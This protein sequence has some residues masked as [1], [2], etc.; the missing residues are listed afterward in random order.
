MQNLHK[1]LFSQ[2]FSLK[3][4]IV[5]LLHINTWTIHLTT[6]KV[7]CAVLENRQGKCG[8]SNSQE[9]DQLVSHHASPLFCFADSGRQPFVSLLRTEFGEE[10]HFQG[11][12][13]LR[14]RAEGEVH[15]LVE[16]LRDV[17]T[18]HVHPPREIRLR[19]AQFLHPAQDA[20]EKRRSDSVYDFHVL[21]TAVAQE[22]DPPVFRY[23]PRPWGMQPNTSLHACWMTFLSFATPIV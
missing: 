23:A 22:R 5:Q 13:E 9:I 7:V 6:S 14:R 20:P 16:D 21:P 2:Q 17:R 11:I 12:R 18:R 15:V 10:I 1:T 19:H 3:P 4:I 8:R